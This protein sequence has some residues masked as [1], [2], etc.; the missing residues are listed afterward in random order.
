MDWKTKETA[1]AIITSLNVGDKLKDLTNKHLADLLLKHIWSK[2]DVFS[3][4][5]D[6]LEEVIE[7][8]RKG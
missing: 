4:E 6:L 5:S 2:Y 8:L 3:H 1:K 7:R